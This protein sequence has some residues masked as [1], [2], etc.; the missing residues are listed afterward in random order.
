MMAGLDM[1]RWFPKFKNFRDHQWIRLFKISV[2][3][4]K[5]TS[6]PLT[7]VFGLQAQNS[8]MTPNFSNNFNKP[9]NQIA[10]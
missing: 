1:M 2:K 4:V 9:D 6:V 5:K 8:S 3:R 7:G 10:P